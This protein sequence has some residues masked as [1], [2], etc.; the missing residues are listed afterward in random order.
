MLVLSIPREFFP[1][2]FG[3]LFPLQEP[4]FSNSIL[5]MNWGQVCKWTFSFSFYIIT[6]DILPFNSKFNESLQ[7]A[8]TTTCPTLDATMTM[9][10]D[11]PKKYHF[12]FN[13]LHFWAISDLNIG[14]V[15]LRLHVLMLC[16]WLTFCDHFH[17]TM[18]SVHGDVHHLGRPACVLTHG[19]MNTLSKDKN[20]IVT[21]IQTDTA[22]IKPKQNTLI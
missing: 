11:T 21:T 17:D 13:C 10:C 16:W 18:Y 7:V 20:E 2:F 9:T 1:G 8:L 6:V 5:T 15:F 19:T 12:E 3:I 4:T 14:S 22:N